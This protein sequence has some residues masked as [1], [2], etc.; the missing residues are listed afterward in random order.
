MARATHDLCDYF[1]FARAAKMI[2]ELLCQPAQTMAGVASHQQGSSSFLK[3]RTK[4]LF[5]LWL[6][7]AA[8]A[9]ANSEI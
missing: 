4:K 8:R 2:L 1:G 9:R 5:L 3:K 6:G 7:G